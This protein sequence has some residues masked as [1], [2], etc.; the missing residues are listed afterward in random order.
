[1]LKNKIKAVLGMILV[2]SMMFSSPVLAEDITMND[3]TI[4]QEINATDVAIQ[5]LL[6]ER[7]T[8]L[9]GSFST[10]DMSSQDAFVDALNEID[11]KLAKLGVAFLDEEEV[12][13]Q[14]PD[15]KCD[16]ALSL[17][18]KT[19][20]ISQN[21]DINANRPSSE[22]NSWLTYR[23]TYVTDGTTYNIQRLIAQPK[24]T[25]SPLTD[26][27][28]RIVTF[29]Q[30]WE[31]GVTNVIYSLAESAVGLIP[32]S[33]F[34][35][36][37]YGAASEFLSGISTTTEVSVPNITY[38][39]SSTTTAVFTYVRLDEQSDDYQWLSLISTKTQ[40]AVGYNIPTFN[41]EQSNGTWGISPEIIQ[42]T[43]TIEN[44]PT[45]Y[46]SM[47]VAIAAYNT[48][49]GGP[50]RNVVSNI[51]I[52]GPESKSVETIWPCCPNFPLQC[53]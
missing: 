48:V 28:S 37:V 45:G 17:S 26:M 44:V 24:S 27:G 1:M 32:G 42:G 41:Y 50:V 38:S 3:E 22:N 35:L 2:I 23:T 5:A 39:W 18:G 16:K 25:D 14:F 30:N 20:Q 29:S 46:D 51:Q 12:M 19:Q 7:A 10:K 40:T 47:E 4:Y 36:T 34:A 31:A 6:D 8:I 53:E 52:S 11:L 43:R 33:T 9:N 49:S 21:Y 13:E 15:T